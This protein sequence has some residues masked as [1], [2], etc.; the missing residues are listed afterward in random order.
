MQS[1]KL[2]KIMFLAIRLGIA[3][4][5]AKNL[6][7]QRRTQNPNKS[8]WKKTA[9]NIL[10]F[11]FNYKTENMSD[12]KIKWN[13]CEKAPITNDWIRIWFSYI[14]NINHVKCIWI[15]HNTSK[16]GAKN[17]NQLLSSSLIS[18]PAFDVWWCCCCCCLML[19]IHL[20][21]LLLILLLLMRGIL[22][23]FSDVACS[24]MIRN[25]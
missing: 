3:I 7:N 6:L 15:C 24:C 11:K 9:E 13:K 19:L 14:R 8:K 5:M 16:R 1:H 2:L 12:R 21:Q 22:Q 10:I 20:L 23:M 4:K 18:N 25:A 17:F